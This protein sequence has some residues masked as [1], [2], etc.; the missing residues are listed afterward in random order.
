[1]RFFP[2]RFTDAWIIEPQVHR[3]ERGFFL[4]SYSARVF[5]DHGIGATFVQDNHALSTA[6]GVLRGL[7]FQAPPHGQS[8]LIRVLHGAITDVIVDL[9]T[10]SP[11]YGAWEQIVLSDENFRMLYIPAG[12]AHGYCTLV[13]NTEIH[14]KVDAFYAPASEGGIRWNDPE[15]GIDWPTAAPLISAKDGLLQLLRD[16]KSP[17]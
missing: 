5:A 2:T 10:K 4:E 6:R 12:F 3:D 15:L 16:L 13:E 9:R 11:T 17:F 8:K 7:H 1:M 14:Y